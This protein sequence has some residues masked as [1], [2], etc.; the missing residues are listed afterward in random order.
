M[1]LIHF[2]GR[3]T[4]RSEDR[5][6]RTGRVRKRTGKQRNPRG[7]PFLRFSK[8]AGRA[9][10]SAHPQQPPPAFIPYAVPRAWLLAAKANQAVTS[11][12]VSI[13]RGV[14]SPEFA[15]CTVASRES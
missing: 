3:Y 12:D 10:A 7:R 13:R 4:A 6:R 2:A 5:S 8:A 11:Y 1:N 14:A 9:R 15:I